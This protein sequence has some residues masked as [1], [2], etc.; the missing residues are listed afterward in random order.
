MEWAEQLPE[1]CPPDD[2]TIP[3]GEI[4]FRFTKND[5]PTIVDFSSQRELKPKARFSWDEC[6]AR[7]VSLQ[8][9][10]NK[11]RKLLK[12]PVFRGARVLS[13]KLTRQ[14]GKIKN[15]PSKSSGKDHFSWWRA[16]D[17]D[18]INNCSFV[19]GNHS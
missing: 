15:T 13:V 1:N 18:V 14:S 6:L 7:A 12:T 3:N 5:L 11:A 19:E 2:S 10:I 4:Y 8:G 16:K 9:D 17:Y